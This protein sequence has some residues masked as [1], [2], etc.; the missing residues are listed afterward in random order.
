MSG[1]V[2][3]IGGG[4]GG[5][6][7]AALLARGGA[8]VTLVERHEQVGGRAGRLEVDGYTFDTG[9]SWYLMPEAFEHF[10][11][12]LGR[13]VEDELDLVD[14]DPRYRVFFERDDAP[15]ADVLEV[16]AS[17]E[18]NRERFDAMSPGDGAAIDEYADESTDLYRL[19]LD[20][21]LYTTFERPLS[22]ADRALVPKL[23]S[24]A[25]LLTQSLGKRIARRV[26]DPRLR[27]LLGF[28][29]VFLGS[30]PDRVP[31][32]FS[33]MSHLDLRDGVRYPKGGLYAVI[34][35]LERVAVAEGVKIRTGADVS[36]I[37]VDDGRATGV[38]LASGELLTADAVVSAA[39][40][41]HT[42]TEL[43]APEHQSRPEKSWRKV[44]PG[45]SALLVMAG[46]EG[47]LPEI[48]HHSL[49]FTKDWDA[50][51]RA[52]MTGGSVPHPA[53]VYVARTTA[54]DPSTAPAGH[55]NLVMLVPFPAE[56][57]LGATDESRAAMEQHA[58][59]YLDQV[60]AW[61]GVPDLR[62]RSTIKAI[63]T[64]AHFAESL[65][66]FRGGAL[67]LEHTLMQ[68]AMF[69]PKNVSSKVSHLLYAGASTAP[70]IGVP[71]CLI[72]AELVA[73]RLLG[74]TSPRPLNTPLPAGYLSRSRKRG[75]L[76]DLARALG[77]KPT[78]ASA[79]D[80][81]ERAAP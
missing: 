78:A 61:A 44:R 12:L 9:P 1:P 59:R 64:P 5:L 29:A 4:V 58:Q 56:P 11:A 48:A 10:F 42:E 63:L 14:L 20:R 31:S 45:V 80:P 28:H 21:F 66:A 54:T 17:K 50:N 76:G 37:V 2:I 57:S 74:E 43:L 67:G 62:S 16:T 73:K 32:L 46:V 52:I 27:Q 39:D 70:G 22:V 65:S 23:A 3:V 68:S 38:R 24:L 40:M 41:H 25:P 13:R 55:E 51:F 18:T 19:A 77:A 79:A 33:L 15:L 60:G 81:S 71:I 7:T 47:E 30:S 53:S 35:A 36:Q 69:R 26:T 49:F 72:S 8:D 6:A 75:P 34:E